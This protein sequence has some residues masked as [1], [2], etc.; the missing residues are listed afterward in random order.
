MRIITAMIQPFMLSKVTSTLEA[1]EG[2]PGMTITQAHGFGRRRSQ[3]EQRE[4]SVAEFK[5]K[6][7]LEIVTPSD[8]AQQIVETLARAAHTG[9]NGDGKVFVW[10]VE[11]AVRIQT[12][13]KDEAAL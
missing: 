1:I 12:G 8:K 6:V 5:E 9:N 3:Q 11:E 13:E 2:F 7:R 10:S 4:L